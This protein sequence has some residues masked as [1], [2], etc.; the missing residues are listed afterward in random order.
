[1]L[2]EYIYDSM[3]INEAEK[4]LFLTITINNTIVE[5]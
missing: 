4:I 3:L 5:Y 2:K 1:M